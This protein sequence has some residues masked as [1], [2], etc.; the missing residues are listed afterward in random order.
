MQTTID[1]A[2]ELSRRDKKTL[3]QKTLKLMEEAG[4]LAKAVLP[5]EGASGCQHRFPNLD[6]VTEEC[7]D[8][9]LVAYSI[10][11]SLG[12]SNEEL[13]AMV[14]KKATYWKS[15]MDAEE[16]TDMEKLGFEI[17][18]TVEAIKSIE[19]FKADCE[20]LGVKPIVLDL[21]TEGEPIK[22]V[23]TSSKV[24]GTT[25]EAAT[26]SRNLVA[27][28]KALGYRVVREK[29]ETVPW[30]PASQNA[31]LRPSAAKYFEAHLAFRASE[32]SAAFFA[33]T[34]SHRIRLSRNTMKKGD[35]SMQMGTLRRS[36]SEMTSEEFV[37]FVE[38]VVQQANSEGFPVLENPHTEYALHDD[39][40]AHDKEW[41]G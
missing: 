39:N 1:L 9:L 11:A 26:A 40:H 25:I 29:V 32:K 12:V 4:E 3:S 41:I 31:H 35:Q 34:N 2:N 18:I 19:S 15:L 24:Y 8:V 5:Y 7:A 27:R 14:G 10:A 22:D 30:H 23:M 33:F 36:S 13:M 20:H 16:A 28:L 37:Q 38:E 6:K 21:Y 17:H